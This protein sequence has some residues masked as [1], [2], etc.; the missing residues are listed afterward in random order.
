M[1]RP[2]V[3]IG[4]E[5]GQKLPPADVP[6]QQAAEMAESAMPV[7]PHFRSGRPAFSRRNGRK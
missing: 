3:E 7:Y 5:T 4:G 1:P 2:E 6:A